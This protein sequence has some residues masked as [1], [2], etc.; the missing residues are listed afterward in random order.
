MIHNNLFEVFNR[1]L[2]TYINAAVNKEIIL[3]N[4]VLPKGK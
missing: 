3:K 4:S 2:P 1:K